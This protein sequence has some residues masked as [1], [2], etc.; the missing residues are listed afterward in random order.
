L[1]PFLPA[2][3]WSVAIL[4]LSSGPSMQLPSD[5]WELEGLDKIGHF[6]AY[7]VLSFLLLAGFHRSGKSHPLLAILVSVFFGLAMEIMQYAFF[8][9]RYFE[10]GDVLANTLGTLAGYG[11]F[12]IVIDHLKL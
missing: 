5:M 7:A 1:K 9:H 10:W 8:P 6:A 3:I 12:K 4:A 2:I 11:V